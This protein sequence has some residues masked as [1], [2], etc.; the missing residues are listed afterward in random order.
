M[1]RCGEPGFIARALHLVQVKENSGFLC[2]T[3]YGSIAASSRTSFGENAPD[4]SSATGIR[5]TKS[6]RE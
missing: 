3:P 1:E 6:S 2:P 4:I 5:G